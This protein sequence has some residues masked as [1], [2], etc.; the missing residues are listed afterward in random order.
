MS[1]DSRIPHTGIK[2]LPLPD[3]SLS[4]ERRNTVHRSIGGNF[5]GEKARAKRQLKA[6]KVHELRAKMVLGLELTLDKV[7]GMRKRTLIGRLEYCKFTGPEMKAWMTSNWEPVIGY[8]P[9]FS[10]LMK[11]WFCFHFISESEATDILDRFWTIQ[12]G[13]LVL[14]KWYTSFDTE[15]T[16]IRKRHLWA[17]LPGFPLH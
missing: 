4:D 11:G 5:R 9:R 6:F 8:T 12:K 17:L 14:E 15:T 3:T 16:P 7:V 1:R 10:V 2:T 13:S